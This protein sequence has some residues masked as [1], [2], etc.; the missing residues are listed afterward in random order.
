MPDSVAPAT[1]ELRPVPAASRELGVRERVTWLL[2][3]LGSW[4]LLHLY[5]G[6][7]HDSIMYTLQGLA[8]VHPDYWSQDIYLR[9]GSQDQFSLFPRLFARCIVWFGLDP[10]AEVLTA[11]SEIAFFLAAWRLARLL[12]PERAALMGLFLLVAL[13]GTY[14][15][16]DIFH[17]VE[18]FNTPRL[19]AEALVLAAT[20]NWLQQR[21]LLA[22]ACIAAGLLVHPLMTAGGIGLCLWLG[23]V[24]SKPRWALWL[25]LLS[26]VALAL[27]RIVASGPPLRFD[28]FWFAVTPT[29]L[30]YLLISHWNAYI[31]SVT[32]LPLVLLCVGSIV[33]EQQPARRLAQAALGI[34]IAGIALSAYGGDWLHLTLIVQGQPWRAMWL[35]SVIATL[36][37]PQIAQQLWRAHAFGRALAFVLVAESALMG[38]RY[39]AAIAP[40]ALLLLGLLVAQRSGRQIPL[41]HQRLALYGS[42]LILTLSLI[43][44]ISDLLPA[45][46]FDFFP[47]QQFAAPHWARRTRELLHNGTLAFALLGVFAW[48]AWPRANRWSLP[49]LLAV[50]AAA[51]CAMVPMT[52][53]AWS[54]ITFAPAEMQ[55][56]AEWRDKIPPG[57]EVLFPEDPIFTWVMLERPS[58]LSRSQA[59]SALFS[60]SAAMFIYGRVE[61]LRPY[62]RTIG[63]DFWDTD[64]KPDGSQPTLARAC[65]VGDLQ[66][67]VSRANF[68]ATPIAEAPPTTK[69]QFGGLKLYRCPIES[70]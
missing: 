62:L 43:V 53:Q 10:A 3:I 68:A 8:H 63:E 17:I 14:G 25:A 67:V 28:D 46:N 11:I 18:D 35:S 19:L 61:A 23:L 37:L 44:L 9:F 65:A 54:R 56:F 51:C 49:V 27:V 55:Q 45:I 32:L 34:G 24:Q 36:L 5:E 39:S 29:A 64:P 30:S 20:V 58:Y 47:H 4:M 60:R 42:G 7:R 59:T 57:S 52:W 31:W 13:P 26:V 48:A 66:F 70:S 6:L 69:S 21:W 33:I 2:F 15:S 38:E 12:L 40:I 22:I 16:I 50:C 1:H 41:R